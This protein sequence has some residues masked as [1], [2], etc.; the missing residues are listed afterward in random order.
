[1]SKKKETIEE[2]LEQ[3][4]VPE[5]EQPYEI[6]E[7]WIWIRLKTINK[8]KKRNIEAKKFADECFELYSVPSFATD[9]PEYVTG[10]EIGSSK[11][12]VEQ[13]DVLLCKIN[14]RINRVWIVSDNHNQYRQ[15]A[16]TEWIVIGQNKC[17]YSKYLLFLLRSPYFR[18]LIC[19]NV[20]GVGGSLTRARPKEVETYPIALP[21]LNEQKRIAEKVERLLERIDEAKVLIEEAKETFELRRVAILN[22]A[23]CGGVNCNS[24]NQNSNKDHPFEIPENWDW[25]KFDDIAKVCS[26]LV[27]PKLY[28]QLPHIAPDNI[29]KG[30]GNLLEYKT[31]GESKVKSSKHYF[32]EGQILYSKIRP[33]LSKVVIAEFD[34]LCSADMYPIETSLNTK[35]LFWY[36]LSPVFTEQASTAGS[37]SVLPK[38]NKKELGRIFIPVPPEYIQEKIVS[39]IE[40]ALQEEG[41]TKSLL[42]NSL[43]RVEQIKQS[44]L[45]RAFSGELG[46]NDQTEESALELLKEV[47][48]EKIK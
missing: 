15:L 30:T 43:E 28:E 10:K 25:K 46:T 38:I 31:I 16:S 7:N 20:S 3:E 18:K 11:Q 32:Y 48:Q 26:N 33:Y 5:E 21:P 41:V 23:F 35:Y 1:M 34:G 44:V 42:E 2:L 19:A 45:F 22:Q 13:Q 9:E 37:R 14:P 47:L 6:P 29:E 27:D 8:N 39:F 17:V 40:K 12:L 4:I 36:M 24:Y